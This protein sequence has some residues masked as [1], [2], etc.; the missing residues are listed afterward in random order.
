MIRARPH[1]ANAA[2]LAVTTS[3]IRR[4]DRR[5]YNAI[6]TLFGDIAHVAARAW[7]AG[8]NRRTASRA[9]GAARLSRGG[10]RREG[11]PPLL[12]PPA[13]PRT[14]TRTLAGRVPCISAVTAQ[15]SAASRSGDSS[16]GTHE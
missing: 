15:T 11:T 5:L 13:Y 9:V 14:C 12:L 3:A 2:G 10:L 7:R 1:L 8:D 16:P 4:S 6:Q